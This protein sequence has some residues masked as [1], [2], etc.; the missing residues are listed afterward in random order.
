VDVVCLGIVVADVICRPVDDLPERGTL[1]LV[2]EVALRGGGCALNTASALARLGLEAGVA[3]KVGADRFG[4][5]LAE[6]LDERGV[7]RRALV[8]DSR[9]P[10]SA[11]VALVGSDGTRT[12]LHVPGANGTLRPDELD[13][14]LLFAGRALHAAGQLVMPGLDGEPFAELLA[15]AR[16][17]GIATSVDTVFDASGRWA[18][19]LPSL[20]HADLFTPSLAEARAISG[21]P[22]PARAAAWLRARGAGAVA[23]TLGADGCYASGP[24]FDGYVAS[25]RVEQVD[26]TGAGDAFAAGLLYATL[27]GRSFEAALRFACAAGAL[28]T[29]AVGAYDGVGHVGETLAL[30]GLA[31]GDS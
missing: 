6:L 25:P 3:G 17:R 26:G 31:A 9:A 30:A 22:D 8:R 20:A 10:T 1:G 12:F 14:E 19:V 29:T 5:F 27:A 28:A 24:G 4:D 7:D 11:T 23:V 15:E 18:L 21:E 2:D 13:R 16:R